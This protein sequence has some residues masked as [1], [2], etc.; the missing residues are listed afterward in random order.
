[1]NIKSS[2]WKIVRF[3]YIKKR[4][5]YSNDEMELFKNNP[6]NEKMLSMAPSIMNA[7]IIA[8][9]I[10]SHGCNSLH[11]V[12]DQ[13]HFDGFGNLITEL[14]PNKIC[15][16]AFYAP[17][18]TSISYQFFYN[19]IEVNGGNTYNMSLLPNVISANLKVIFGIALLIGPNVIVRGIAKIRTIRT[20]RTK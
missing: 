8:T 2:I 16:Y 10:E 4:L 15:I 6:Q 14:S 19:T 3:N 18:A 20:I 9:V 12:G 7:S 11:K 1:M 13:F 5:T 17:S